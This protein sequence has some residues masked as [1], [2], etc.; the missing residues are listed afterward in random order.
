MRRTVQLLAGVLIL[1]GCRGEQIPTEA[2]MRAQLQANAS[3][4][5]GASVNRHLATLRQATAPFQ[6]SDS[7]PN[8]GRPAPIT[9]CM[10]DPR[11]AGG[12]GPHYGSVG[13][14]HVTV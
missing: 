2:A 6:R 14:A 7:A 9:A 11:R 8:A 13:R 10:T 4:S 1:G 12:T 3:Q 5:F